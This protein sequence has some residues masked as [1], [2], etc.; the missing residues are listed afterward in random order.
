MTDVPKIQNTFMK[1]LKSHLSIITGIVL[2]I[3]ASNCLAATT[4]T[5]TS[6]SA[7]A[8]LAE[9]NANTNLAGLNYGAAG[10][11]AIASASS[12]NGAFDSIVQFN[13][14]GAAAQFNSLFGPGNWGITGIQLSLASNFGTNGAHPNNGLF[15]NISG[16]QFGLDWLGNNSW[17]EGT[18]G[19]NGTPGYP[20]NNM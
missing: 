16:G 20:A 4:Y 1:T 3:G 19:G 11:L 13:A 15:G 14:S 7:D 18:G 9:G 17:T 8:F 2:A 6:S 5:I 10:T 12:P